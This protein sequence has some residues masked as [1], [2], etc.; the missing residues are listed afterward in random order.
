MFSCKFPISNVMQ[1]H[2]AGS[3]LIRGDGQTDM[4]KI[5]LAFG[6]FA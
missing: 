1:I 2:L 6:E 3:A 5:I 4:A